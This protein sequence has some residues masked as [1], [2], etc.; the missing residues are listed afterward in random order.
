MSFGSY[1]S[2]MVLVYAAD[3]P[4]TVVFVSA[5]GVENSDTGATHAYTVL[6]PKKKV[7]KMYS[8]LFIGDRSNYGVSGYK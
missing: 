4:C 8:V 6:T 3:W 5:G 7:M 2:S 1:V